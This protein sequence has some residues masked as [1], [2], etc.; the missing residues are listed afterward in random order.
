[1]SMLRPESALAGPCVEYELV[2]D[3][4]A[5][6]FARAH[7][8][9]PRGC[10]QSSETARSKEQGEHEG[11]GES[12]GS[13]EST[14]KRREQGSSQPILRGKTEVAGPGELE[15]RANRVAL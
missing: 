13:A 14:K 7:E 8:L 4:H 11:A 10:E 9:P 5:E 1:M 2:V 12:A 3:A 15:G 6:P